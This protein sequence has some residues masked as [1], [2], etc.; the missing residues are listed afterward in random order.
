M[1]YAPGVI[2]GAIQQKDETISS[3]RLVVGVDNL[4]EAVEKALKSGASTFI[5]QK[6]LPHMKYCVIIDTEGNEVNVVD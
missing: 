1:S 4:E 6:Q 5:T 2:N 3:T